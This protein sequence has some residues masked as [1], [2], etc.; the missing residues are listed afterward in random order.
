MN[1]SNEIKK[2]MH[3]LSKN[4]KT[5]F[6]GQS[7][8]VPGN[9]LFKSLE[10]VPRKK[11]LELPVFEETQ[12]GMAIG[13]SLNGFIPLTCYPRFDFFILSMNQTINHLDKLNQ[14]SSKEFDPFVI[15]RVLVGGKKSIDAG[16]QHTG[17][18]TSAMRKMLKFLN[19]I[20][21]KNSS[22][23]YKSYKN[24]IN[25]KKSTLFVEYSDSY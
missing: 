14:I 21:L 8:E 6:L 23:I 2:S 25:K 13:L 18:Y 7:V 17:N 24:C 16:P 4:P 3:M 20:E 11:K 19:V 9:L 1:Y 12:M 22:Q 15:I 10:R 5:I